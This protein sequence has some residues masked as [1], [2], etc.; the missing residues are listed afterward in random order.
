METEQLDAREALEAVAQGRREAADRLVTPW[1][2]HPILGALIGALIVVQGTHSLVLKSAVPIAAIVGMG[3]LIR[4]YT[5]LTGLWVS[6]N[7]RGPAGR[8]TI[9]L[10]VGYLGAYAVAAGFG[11]LAASIPAAVFVVVFTVV[12]GRGFDEALRREIRG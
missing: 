2:Y 11:S 8:W 4:S 12:V 6:G 10:V 5:R 7:R 1:W 9:A 3:V